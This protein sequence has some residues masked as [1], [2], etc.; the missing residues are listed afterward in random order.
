MDKS[1]KLPQANREAK[2]RAIWWRCWEAGQGEGRQAGGWARRGVEKG[3]EEEGALSLQGVTVRGLGKVPAAGI[4]TIHG[5]NP[6]TSLRDSTF[7][8]S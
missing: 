7:F 2:R 3:Q 4:M 8:K 6:Y 1:P 5:P